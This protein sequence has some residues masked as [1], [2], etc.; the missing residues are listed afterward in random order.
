MH[1]D[2]QGDRTVKAEHTEPV[3]FFE[4]RNTPSREMIAAMMLHSVLSRTQI[5]LEGYASEH[6]LEDD[7]VKVF[8]HFA[9]TMADALLAELDRRKETT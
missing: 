2:I 8:P 3:E 7:V 1:G 9:V 5:H 6:G 4:N